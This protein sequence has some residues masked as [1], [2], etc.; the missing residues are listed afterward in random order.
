[1]IFRAV[2]DGTEF[3]VAVHTVSG[4]KDHRVPG[5]TPERRTAFKQTVLNHILEQAKV[6][7]AERGQQ[8]HLIVAGDL[9]LT[10]NAAA[11]VVTAFWPDDRGASSVGRDKD[12]VM[13][14]RL[15]TDVPLKTPICSPDPAH[16]SVS[17]RL[18][19]RSRSEAPPR[20]R[21]QRP[22]PPPAAAAGHRPRTSLRHAGPESTPSLP[23]RRT[24]RA[25]SPRRH[26]SQRRPLP[27]SPW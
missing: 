16:H 24:K 4:A 21:R 3:L 14:T 11:A 1:M 26:P 7:A 23:R 22:S 17:A 6:S 13:A 18:Q 25:R 10:Q 9:N 12:F 19:Q 2:A 8:C 5:K 15:S 20:L 27:A